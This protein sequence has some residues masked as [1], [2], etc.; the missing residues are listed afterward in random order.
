MADKKEIVSRETLEVGVANSMNEAAVAKL[1]SIE[2][3]AKEAINTLTAGIDYGTIP[4]TSKPVLL[5]PGA[6]KILLSLGISPRYEIMDQIEIYDEGR[7]FAKYTVRCLLTIPNPNNPNEPHIMTEGI[8]MAHTKEKNVGTANP[9][10]Q[11]NTKLKIA[12]KRAMVDATIGISGL[13]SQFTQDLVEEAAI[14]GAKAKADR[15]SVLRVYS[16][17]YKHF[18]LTTDTQKEKGKAWLDKQIET[19]MFEKEL[20]IKTLFAK[21]MTNELLKEFKEYYEPLLSNYEYN[22][23][24]AKIMEVKND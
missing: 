9:L 2:E 6:E 18:E 3:F 14:G 10:D 16:K 17:I 15:F 20:P 4:S 23:K 13:S 8:G 19:F 7:E 22:K 21:E 1:A 12:K 11:F 24:K 5:K